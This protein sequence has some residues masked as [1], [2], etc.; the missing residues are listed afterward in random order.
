MAK[1]EHTFRIEDEKKHT[2][3][4]TCAQSGTFAKLIYFEKGFLGARPP[5]TITL[6][7]EFETD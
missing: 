6:T 1:A 4:Y 5:K 2:I 7:A 3:R